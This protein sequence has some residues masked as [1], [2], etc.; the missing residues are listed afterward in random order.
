M[1]STAV[2]ITVLFSL[3]LIQKMSEH[4]S[5]ANKIVRVARRLGVIHAELLPHLDNYQR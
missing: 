4:L 1:Y 2:C 3:R 5:A